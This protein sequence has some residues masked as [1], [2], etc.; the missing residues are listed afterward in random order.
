MFAV[1][2]RALAF[3]GQDAP[4]PA[5]ED[6]PLCGRSFWYRKDPAAAHQKVLKRCNA[7]RYFS[8][9]FAVSFPNGSPTD[10]QN[11]ESGTAK[12]GRGVRKIKKISHRRSS[13][14]VCLL[15]I[16]EHP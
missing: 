3:L 9:F 7:R 14:L 4:R 6:R 12:Y 16:Q 10:C 8:A 1:V 15:L 5:V 2:I 13:Q 11:H